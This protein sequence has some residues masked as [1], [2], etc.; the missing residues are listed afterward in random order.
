MITMMIVWYR[1]YETEKVD[2]STRK[3]TGRHE[4]CCFIIAFIIWLVV[5]LSEYYVSSKA[6]KILFTETKLQVF[7][8]LPQFFNLLSGEDQ[9]VER[10]LAHLQWVK[11]NHFSKQRTFTSALRFPHSIASSK[12]EPIH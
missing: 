3:F 9:I 1:L 11:K 10:V 2:Y 4:S 7:S 8:A 6:S 5:L 12:R